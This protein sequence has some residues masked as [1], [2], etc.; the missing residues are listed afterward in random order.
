MEYGILFFLAIVVLCYLQTLLSMR[1]NKYLGLILP[2]L[3]FVSSFFWLINMDGFSLHSII[4]ALF[5]IIVANIPTYILLAIYYF[6]R[7]RYEKEKAEQ[8][9][10][11]KREF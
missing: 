10:L 5:T 8:E 1:D 2:A 3:L 7:K 6:K 4:S 11:H 9:K